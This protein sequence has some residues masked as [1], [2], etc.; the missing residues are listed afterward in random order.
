MARERQPLA[1]RYSVS[2]GEVELLQDVDRPDGWM[3]TMSGVPQSYVDLSDPTYLDF[4][5]VQL[6]AQVVDSLA[7]GPL[8]VV[9]VGGGAC[10]L[11]R[12][13][14]ATRPGSRHIVIEPDAELVQ[15]VRDHL[16]LKSVPRLKVRILDGR[17]ASAGLADGSADLFVLDAFSGATMPVD[18]ATTQYMADVSRILRADGTLLINVAD[19]K[20][21][22]FTRRVVATVRATFRHVALLAEPGVLRGRRFGNLIVAA[23]PRELPVD[24]LT[25]RAAGGLTQARCVSGDRLADFVAGAA[26]IRDG[27]PVL[28]PQPPPEVFG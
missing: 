6:M 5:Y 23:S 14:A 8:D 1:G 22:A 15:L 7:D 21:L 28:A 3:L 2:F 12:Y 18:L 13:I 19:G 17:T 25:R 10:T 9:H 20:G 24:S 11:P 27:D 16:R 26:P 4:E